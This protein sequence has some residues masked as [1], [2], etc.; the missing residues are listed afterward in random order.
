MDSVSGE[1]KEVSFSLYD[2]V[3]CAYGREAET[4]SE[5]E[6]VYLEL[7]NSKVK[8]SAYRRLLPC[9]TSGARLPG[10]IV[11]TLF[12]RACCPQAFKDSRNWLKTLR[13][14]CAMLRKR[15]ADE[16]GKDQG[17]ALNV[18]KT[19]RDYLYGRLLAVAEY[20]ESSY[21]REKDRILN[22]ET[23]D[24]DD[25]KSNIRTTNAKKYFEAFANHPCNTWRVIR[26]SL[27]PYLNRM[28]YKKSRFCEKMIMDITCMFN[29][30]EFNDNSALAPEFLQAYYC[31]LS[32]LYKS[33]TNVKNE[34]D[35]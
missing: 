10:D 2:I 6:R 9:I 4:K 27:Q 11:Q 28:N 16:K 23:D 1:Y 14:A 12:V 15:I 7:D 19:T 33:K 31:Q 32:E 17:M 35:K 21:Y 20:A 22:K 24:S 25:S 26:L 5:K 29:D 18:N 30:D 13:C 3:S 34:E 8:D